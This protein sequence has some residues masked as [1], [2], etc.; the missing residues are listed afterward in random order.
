MSSGISCPC[1]GKDCYLLLNHPWCRMLQSV[2]R[3]AK[4]VSQH[5]EGREG[6]VDSDYVYV[7]LWSHRTSLNQDKFRKKKEVISYKFRS[8]YSIISL[9]QEYHAASVLLLVDGLGSSFPAWAPASCP[10]HFQE[11]TVHHG[12]CSLGNDHLVTDV[13]PL[14]QRCT[15]L[16]RLITIFHV[17]PTMPISWPAGEEWRLHQYHHLWTMNVWIIV[18]WHHLVQH[19]QGLFLFVLA[20]HFVASPGDLAVLLHCTDFVHPTHI[21]LFTLRVCSILHSL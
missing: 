18:L 11:F 7:I 6:S 19:T 4:V 5:S 2:R 9:P 16:P 15:F 13:L 20:Y 17:N 14:H 10:V 1:C 8:R 3:C 12:I 21:S